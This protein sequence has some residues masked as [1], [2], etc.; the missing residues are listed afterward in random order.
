[1]SKH[2]KQQFTNPN[3][4]WATNNRQKHKQIP[5]DNIHKNTNINYKLPKPRPITLKDFIYFL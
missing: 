2:Y 4:F 5:L 3:P 1:M